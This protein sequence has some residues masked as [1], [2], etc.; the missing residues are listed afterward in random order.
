VQENNYPKVPLLAVPSADGEKSGQ[1]VEGLQ[2]GYGGSVKSPS[3]PQSA[4]MGPIQELE[5]P[6]QSP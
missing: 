1:F 5:I 4:V 6:W 3:K 2:F